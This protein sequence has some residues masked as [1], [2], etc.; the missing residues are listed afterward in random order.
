ML[1]DTGAD[2]RPAQLSVTAIHKAIFVGSH[3]AANEVE[4]LL[5]FKGVLF[6]SSDGSYSYA[7]NNSDAAVQ[8]LN[9]GQ[10]IKIGR[11]SCRE[12]VKI[13]ETAVSIKTKTGADDGTAG[14]DD[15]STGGRAWA[16]AESAA[17]NDRTA[18]P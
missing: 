3:T 7:V 15:N 4:T 11:A 2:N 13:T 8:A 17:L 10:T 14:V 18:R 5:E 1:H 12:S 6:L 9:V 16:A